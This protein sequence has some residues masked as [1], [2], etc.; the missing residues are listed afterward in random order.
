MRKYLNP[1]AEEV[2]AKHP[3]ISICDQWSFVKDHADD[4]YRD[5]WSGTD[6]HFGGGAADALGEYLGQH[7]LGL[8]GL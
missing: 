6:V 5:W 3:E 1:W 2:M 4:L 7:I 8:T